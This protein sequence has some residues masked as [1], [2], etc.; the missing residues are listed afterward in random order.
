MDTEG[1][2]LSGIQ[3]EMNNRN[4]PWIA[5]QEFTEL[6]VLN[7]KFLQGE[8]LETPYYCAPIDEETLPLVEGLLKVHDLGLLTYSS[9][10]YQDDRCFR[11]GEDWADYQQR[12]FLSFLVADKDGLG[13]ELFRKLQERPEI[14]VQAAQ[15]YPY[16]LWPGSYDGGLVVTRE[17]IVDSVDSLATTPWQD[18]T[19]VCHSHNLEEEGLFALEVIRRLN[20]LSIEC[21]ANEWGPLD[22]ISLVEGVAIECGLPRVQ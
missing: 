1:H 7:R 20:P 15:S 3:A 6:L 12:P 8:I 16:R 2:H 13:L 19:E 4:A 21:A 18:L 10:P 9:Q 22:L 14:V 5:V 17:R 11:V